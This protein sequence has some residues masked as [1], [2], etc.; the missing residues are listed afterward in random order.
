[1]GGGVVFHPAFIPRIH[2]FFIETFFTTP[3][4]NAYT[5]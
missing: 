4:S 3:L 1:V 5:L 2:T